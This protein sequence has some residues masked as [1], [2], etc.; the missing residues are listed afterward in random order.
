MKDCIEL[1][2][3]NHLLGW[4]WK[5]FEDLPA[6]RTKIKTSM[7]I[8]QQISLVLNARSDLIIWIGENLGCYKSKDGYNSIVQK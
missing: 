2:D 5:R 1:I 8:L 4:K 7:D 6:N 3:V